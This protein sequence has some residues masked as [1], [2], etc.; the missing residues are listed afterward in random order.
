MTQNDKNNNAVLNTT[1]NHYQ[2]NEV[3]HYAFIRDASFF[4]SKFLATVV[5][6]KV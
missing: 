2:Q 5:C 1:P 3:V 4:V 6:L